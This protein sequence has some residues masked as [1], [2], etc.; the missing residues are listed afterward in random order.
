MTHLA[1]NAGSKGQRKKVLTGM[2]LFHMFK[3]PERAPV[4]VEI[5]RD[6]CATCLD[7]IHG[8]AWMCTTCRNPQHIDCFAQWRRQCQ[9]KNCAVTCPNCRAEVA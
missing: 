3:R 8:E 2:L 4:E 5:E 7:E 9:F 1:A 6:V